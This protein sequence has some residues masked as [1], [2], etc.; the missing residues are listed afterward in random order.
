MSAVPAE[1]VRRGQQRE[2]AA[3]ERRLGGWRKLPGTRTHT[4]THTQVKVFKNFQEKLQ[5]RIDFPIDGLHGGA[6]A[7]ARGADFVCFYDWGDGRLVRRIDVGACVCARVCVC[8]FVCVRV[9]TPGC[10]EF[11][12]A[13]G[14]LNTPPPPPHHHYHPHPQ[15]PNPPPPSSRRARRDL[16]RGRRAGRHRRGQLVLPPGL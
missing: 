7:G 15:P 4:H 2:R 6:L 10:V 8:M 13:G 1:G 9:C 3:A 14:G 12:C 11:G 16:E 5:L